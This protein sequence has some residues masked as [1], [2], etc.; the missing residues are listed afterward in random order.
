MKNRDDWVALK[1]NLDRG[2]LLS[3]NLT[4]HIRYFKQVAMYAGMK[5]ESDDTKELFIK[6]MSLIPMEGVKDG[7]NKYKSFYE[8]VK[9]AKDNKTRFECLAKLESHY[10]KIQQE[11]I[12]AAIQTNQLRKTLSSRSNPQQRNRYDSNA[13]RGKS[14]QQKKFKQRPI[15]KR[16]AEKICARCG[17]TGHRAEE[18]RTPWSSCLKKKQLQEKLA[19]AEDQQVKNQA[20]TVIDQDELSSSDIS[21]RE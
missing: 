9:I 7:E 15:A 2:R 20:C 18:C 4:A 1:G 14:K 6:T 16:N 8:I 5:A 3:D 17:H 21:D 13:S 19:A 11:S 12:T 10:R